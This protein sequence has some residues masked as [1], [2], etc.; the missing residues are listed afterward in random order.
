MEPSRSLAGCWTPRDIKALDP[1]RIFLIP[2]PLLSPSPILKSKLMGV[3]YLHRHTT[4]PGNFPSDQASF[5]RLGHII[6][7][8]LPL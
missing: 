6:T 7:L 1:L 5:L 4:S 3:S 8:L 2:S